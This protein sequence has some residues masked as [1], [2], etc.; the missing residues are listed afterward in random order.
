MFGDPASGDLKDF[1]VTEDIELFADRISLMGIV[2]LKPFLKNDNLHLLLM[3]RIA[4]EDDLLVFFVDVHFRELFQVTMAGSSGES[5]SQ[6]GGLDDESN[7]GVDNLDGV[8]HRITYRK[9]N[10]SLFRRYP[11]YS[12]DYPNKNPFTNSVK[13]RERI[14]TKSVCDW[15]P[16]R[17]H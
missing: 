2:L 17:N 15:K 13:K 6:E 7:R 3:D 10:R 4:Q 11:V 14:L 16:K 9:A 1:H 5:C 8:S 12:P